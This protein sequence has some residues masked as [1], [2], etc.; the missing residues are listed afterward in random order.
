MSPHKKRVLSAFFVVC[1]AFI[2]IPVMTL[3]ETVAPVVPVEQ[4]VLCWTIE[5]CAKGS[6]GA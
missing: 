5:A 4:N 3:A 1:F 6:R 2:F